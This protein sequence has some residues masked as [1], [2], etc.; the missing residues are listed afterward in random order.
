MN[1]YPTPLPKQK[2]QEVMR[3][4]YIATIIKGAL[5]GLSLG[6]LSAQMAGY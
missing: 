4:I 5:L 6:W 2:I 1:R 3:D